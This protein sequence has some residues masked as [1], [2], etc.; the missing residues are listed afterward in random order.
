[1][2]LINLCIAVFVIGSSL[3]LIM[4]RDIWP[5][6]PYP[7]FAALQP[8]ELDNLDVVGI[9]A[10]G[11]EEI[12]LAPSRRTSIVAGTR[13][14]T[15]LDRLIEGGSEP[16][17]RTYLAALAQRY[18]DSHSEGQARLKFVRVYKTRWHAAPEQQPPARRVDRR[19]LAQLD[20]GH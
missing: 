12:A 17:L 8:P 4:Q 11:S 2:L 14:Q 6:S 18:E 9:T 20:L 15:L 7:M 5:F 3:S 13:F 1:M 10:N 19:L 16:E